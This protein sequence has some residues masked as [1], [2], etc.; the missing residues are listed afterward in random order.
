M[1]GALEDHELHD[2]V[3]WTLER[4]RET[5]NTSTEYGSPEW[6]RLARMACLAMLEASN[7]TQERKAGNS[8]GVPSNPILY[9]R[10]SRSLT[11][12]S[13]FAISSVAT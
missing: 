5:G 3:G 10:M 11:N 7:R 12:P 8:A 6:R 13:A 1:S 9:H 2:L 4:F